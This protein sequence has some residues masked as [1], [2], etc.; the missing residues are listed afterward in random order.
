MVSP[1][2]PGYFPTMFAGVRSNKTA[3]TSVQIART[4]MSLPQPCAPGRE[5][6]VLRPLQDLAG[7]LLWGLTW[8]VA[9]FHAPTGRIMELC[10]FRPWAASSRPWLFEAPCLCC[11]EQRSSASVLRWSCSGIARRIWKLAG[12]LSG[13]WNGVHEVLD[14]WWASYFF[15]I[16][17]ATSSSKSDSVVLSGVRSFSFF[18]FDFFPPLLAFLLDFFGF[19]PL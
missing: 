1:D 14:F 3:P 4:S 8:L 6:I 12:E 19:F 10:S 7:Y 18:F 9:Y 15:I 16:P 13:P 11:K 17:L 5:R 2:F